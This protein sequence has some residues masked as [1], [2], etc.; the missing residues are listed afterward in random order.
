MPKGREP[1]PDGA[2]QY[3]SIA[4][5]P[6]SSD[7]C[8]TRRYSTWLLDKSNGTTSCRIELNVSHVED[9]LRIHAP[10]HA[11]A[12]ICDG[13]LVCLTGLFYACETHAPLLARQQWRRR[14]F[15]IV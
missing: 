12:G 11:L 9:L 6:S 15:L 3:L 1:E 14:R 10:I 5:E 8:L 7:P 13:A 4:T 2:S